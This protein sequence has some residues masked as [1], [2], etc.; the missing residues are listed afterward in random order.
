MAMF[1]RILGITLPIFAIALIGY[2]YSRATKPNLSGANKISVDLALPALIFTSLSA[3][4]F[5]FGQNGPFLAAATA[6]VLVSGLLALPLARIAG[7][8][9]RAFLPCVMFG[10][11]G[12]LGIPLTV[13]AFGQPALAPAVLLLVLSNI[14]HFTVGVWIMSGRADLK[15]VAASPLVWSTLLGLSFSAFRLQ[16]PAWADVTLTMIGNILIPMMLLSLGA[17]LAES[18]T[19][20]WRAGAVGAVVTPLVRTAAALGLL[21]FLPLTDVQRGAFLLFAALPPAV[22]NYLLADRFGRDPEKVASVVMAGHLA[23]IVC[24]PL[25]LLIALE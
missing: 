24:L 19:T 23:S 5:E 25:A 16:L 22:F 11:V 21:L 10:N 17:R 18:Q 6:L 8:D 13:L 1:E 3:K 4:E 14:L 9:R 2:L 7:V 12:P 15:S 20:Q